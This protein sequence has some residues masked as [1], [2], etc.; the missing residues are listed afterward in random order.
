[1]AREGEQVGKRGQFVEGFNLRRNERSRGRAEAAGERGLQGRSVEGRAR[2]GGT[3]VGAEGGG[4]KA[5]LVK[6]E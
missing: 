2:A 3:R 5:R 6:A 4:D 1:M